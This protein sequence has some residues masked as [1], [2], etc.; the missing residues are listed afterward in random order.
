MLQQECPYCSLAKKKGELYCSRHGSNMSE[1]TSG[2]FCIEK[3]FV[4]ECD[5]HV[6][7]LSLNF[8]LDG[9]QTYHT[10]TRAFSISPHKYLLLNEGQKFKTSS[11]AKAPNRMVTVAFQV[12]LADKLVTSLTSASH[13]L[14][15]DPFKNS[16]GSTEFL[17]KTYAMNPTIHSAVSELVDFS[18]ESHELDQRLEDLLLHILQDQL[19]V[20]KEILKI[21]KA[22]ASTKIEIYRRLH[23][24]LD[25]LRENFMS[26]ISVDHMAEEACLSTFHY[27]R[28]FT[29]LFKISPYQYLINLRLEKART[30]LHSGSM[31]H[32][33]CKEVG[34]K[35]PSSFARLFKKRFKTTPLQFKAN[36]LPH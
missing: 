8:N 30:L 26:N 6:T 36:H 2:V 17:E 19:N 29:E 21:S 4:D 33:V 20:R 25:F 15:D 11:Q 23:W 7:R 16:H 28:L 31:I 1:L 14:L 22:K 18:G 35:D 34:W 9:K 13:A 3:D 12:G 32:E 5:W 27:K 24:S 10:P